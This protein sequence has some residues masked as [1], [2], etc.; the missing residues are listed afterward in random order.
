MKERVVMGPLPCLGA[1]NYAHI[2][3]VHYLAKQ[4]SDPGT[5]SMGLDMVERMYGQN[6]VN[7]GA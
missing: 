5:R 7:P 2:R 3:S 6:F 1:R 4:P